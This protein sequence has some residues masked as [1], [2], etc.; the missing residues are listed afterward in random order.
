MSKQA[1]L[2]IVMMMIMMM[3]MIMMIMMLL[4]MLLVTKMTT[5][6]IKIS[7]KLTHK[8]KQLTKVMLVL[9]VTA[10]LPLT[11][12]ITVAQCQCPGNAYDRAA[13]PIFA[14]D[15]PSRSHSTP[16]QCQSQPPKLLKPPGIPAER[17]K[18]LGSD[19]GPLTE[20]IGYTKFIGHFCMSDF[21][22]KF[23]Y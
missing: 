7:Q 10:T 16:K 5:F 4:V 3:I 15:S 6:K 20:Q 23:L 14:N 9:I 2:L 19:L 11:N 13:A 8:L 22:Y 17:L 1:A 18:E 21:G 12:T